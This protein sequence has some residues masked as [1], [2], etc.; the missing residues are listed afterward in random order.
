MTALRNRLIVFLLLISTF[1]FSQ[2]QQ[3]FE[4]SDTFSKPRFWSTVGTS[5]ALF[6][7]TIIGLNEIWYK[8]FERSSFHTFNDWRE[9][10]NMDK[11][12]H[13]FTA[14]FQTS[15][16]FDVMRWTGVDRRNAL[17]VAMGLGTLFQGT[18]EILDGYSEKWGFSVYD[19]GFNTAGIFLF[20]GQEL[21][22]QDQRFVLKVSN[23]FPTYSNEDIL[24]RSGDATSSPAER[25][26]ELYGS[27]L[28]TRF[29]KDYNGQTI[30]LSL[31][32]ASFINSN[33]PFPKWLNVA[34]GYGAENLYGGYVNSWNN[35]DDQ[36]FTLNTPN[37]QR[38]K[39]FFLSLDI[40]LKRIKT[41]KPF[42]RFL[43]KGLNIFKI[44]SPTL[45]LTEGKGIRF[46]A[47]YW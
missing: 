5:T 45:S 32:P 13:A 41:K 35:I 42:I 22:W 11:A 8:D 1:G 44:P 37:F 16:S 12:G 40:D 4:L 10:N 18:I 34:V 28:S 26:E 3:F 14:Y 15:Y 47:L 20:A 27:A 25:A 23:S 29:I 33:T 7:G 46:H 17:W 9:W 38:S 36:S 24:S 2:N 39:Q 21:A 30:W 43:L 31:N 6:T 19:V